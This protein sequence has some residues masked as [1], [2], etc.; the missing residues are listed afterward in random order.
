M[1]FTLPSLERARG[2][3]LVAVL[4]AGLVYFG[5]KVDGVY[6]VKDWLF[7]RYAAYWVVSLAW[8]ASC[9]LAGYALCGV[10]VRG[11]L[12]K[13][14]QLTLGLA[15]GV[16]CFGLGVF[17]V[18]LA[19]GLSVLT[20]FLLPAVFALFGYRRSGKEL[21]HF[22]RRTL[23][24]EWR[25]PAWQVPVLV[26]AVLALGIVYF[27][28]LSPEVVSF[29][30][31]WYHMPIAQRYA[32]SG[33]VS[34]FE[35]GFWPVAFPHLWS[36]VYAWAFLAPKTL[37][38]DRVELCAHLEFVLF[39]AMLAQVPVLVRRLAP[40]RYVGITWVTLLM[41]PGLYVYDLNL[42][43]GADRV[44][45]F[46][47]IPIALTFF[48]AWRRFTPLNAAL[49]SVFIAAATLTKYTAL[50]IV[51]PP[52]FALLARGLWLTLRRRTKTE[53]IALAALVT[54]PLILTAP[55]W[56]K[57]WVWYGDPIYPMLHR[58]F[59]SHPWAPE[60]AARLSILEATGR[61]GSVNAEGLFAAAKATLTFSFEPNNWEFL[62]GN[63]PVFGSLF[64]LTLPCLLFVK[65][66][67]RVAW[68]YAL[69]MAAVFVW[70]LLTHYDRYLVAAVPL[71]AGATA[72]TFVLVARSGYK[73]RIALALLG[74]LQVVWA[75]DTPFIRT[76]NL[77]HDSPIRV[78]ALFLASAFERQ[79]NRLDI[80]EPLS[81]I[82]RALP[83]DATV[84]AHDN[85]MILGLD[86]N[87]VTDLHQLKFN[88]ARLA[89]PARINDQLRRLGV[90]DLVWPPYSIGRDSVGEDL[91]FYNYAYR[92]TE[93]R[94]IVAGQW[95]ARV[96]EPR[97]SE[98]RT[99]F[100]RRLL[101][102]RSALPHGLVQA[103]AA[104]LAR[105]RSG[106]AAR[107]RRATPCIRRSSR[108]G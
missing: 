92:A 27:T 44:T 29:D 20:F 73:P 105:R 96:P 1:P 101:R 108:K 6:P 86:R 95:V 17:F 47:A 64:T 69:G 34:R 2:F 52:A 76:H 70:Y 58:F 56:L 7:L 103:L 50:S 30:V 21:L 8:L 59:P 89:S 60:A 91:A 43:S 79:E 93:E 97:P 61:P 94:R 19:H 87:W 5:V 12:P 68:L 82:G 51:L 18:G 85:I 74:G 4:A 15:L 83:P 23:R 72:T 54:L 55:H 88:Y 62:Y 36:Y 57:N 37:L 46:F 99:E 39:L 10:L 106:T 67:A 104:H 84:L 38:F 66:A 32:L 49:F 35:E 22:A 107:P 13:L 24:S 75:G 98:T 16:L 100:E 63:W 81:T 102:L 48:R 78:V 25:V 53:G 28:I 26:L 3:F 31:R 65:G 40:G 71:M 11:A 14:E 41:F 45:G 77:L 33:A 90:T 9:L 80:Y 42:H